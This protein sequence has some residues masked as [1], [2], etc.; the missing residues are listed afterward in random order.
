MLQFTSIRTNEHISHEESVVGTS[1]HDS[2][3]NSIFFIP[4]CIAVNDVDA[5]PCVQVIDS[6]FSVDSPYL[7][8]AVS[9]KY[10]AMR[11]FV[12]EHVRLF[13]KYDVMKHNANDPSGE[14]AG[15]TTT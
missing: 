14:N 10:S 3:L 12:A 15:L 9:K 5:I 13:G 1:A 6:T 7:E 11:R 8:D 4:S 2:D